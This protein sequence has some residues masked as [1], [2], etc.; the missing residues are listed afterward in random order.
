MPYDTTTPAFLNEP[1]IDELGAKAAANNIPP[2]QAGEFSRIANKFNVPITQVGNDAT[3]YQELDKNFKST[4]DYGDFVA[5]APHAADWMRSN[6]AHIAASANGN[7]MTFLKQ[8]ND[9]RQFT[10]A[11]ERTPW[12]D[13]VGHAFARGGLQALNVVPGALAGIKYA[14]KSAAKNP[15]A[16]G[17]AEETDG[18]TNF[19]ISVEQ[20]R[21]N[22]AD[23]ER[24]Q[25]QSI[26]Q[27]AA[28]TAIE[29]GLDIVTTGGPMAGARIGAVKA[30]SGIAAR[31]ATVAGAKALSAE[32]IILAEKG[33]KAGS[34]AVV[35]EQA[36]AAFKASTIKAAA[37]K[38][39]TILAAETS[40]IQSF[41]ENLSSQQ[42]QG[43][44]TH[45]SASM[46]SQ[47]VVDG[48]ITGVFTK[49]GGLTAE[50]SL[51]H[52]A[53]RVRNLSEWGYEWAKDS[54]SEFG[55]EFSQQMNQNIH[56]G[57][58]VLEGAG[59]A[60]LLGALAAG[61]MNIPGV[62]TAFR[63][64]V[65][66]EVNKTIDAHNAVGSFEVLNKVIANVKTDPTYS[67]LEGSP[68][69]QISQLNIALAQSEISHLSF[70]RE[71]I[72]AYFAK[73]GLD[74]VTVFANMK[75]TESFNDMS[76]PDVRVE[77][78][79]LLQQLM[80]S[81][82]SPHLLP[83]IEMAKSDKA[84]MSFKSAVK[85]FSTLTDFE[86]RS[87]KMLDEL[88]KTPMLPSGVVDDSQD[89]VDAILPEWK[90]AEKGVGVAP[91]ER[92][93]ANAVI[94]A[95]FYRQ[96][97]ETV[98][99]SGTVT[100]LVTPKQL[101]DQAPL[102]AKRVAEATTVEEGLAK[103]GIEA[104][105]LKEG[106]VAKAPTKAR[107]FNLGKLLATLKNANATTLAHES[108]HSFLNTWF[109]LSAS[110]N[111]TA[112]SRADLESLKLWWMGT[113]STIGTTQ[114]AEISSAA[115]AAG[116]T[117]EAFY[118]QEIEKLGTAEQ[119]HPA[120]Y[121][122]A[123]EIF[124][125]GWE[126]YLA[127][128]NAPT[129]SL[130]KIFNNFGKWIGSLV[131]N[132]F[133]SGA[134]I[135]K[136][137]RDVFGRMLI[138]EADIQ[139]DRQAVERAPKPIFYGT[140][141]PEGVS[142]ESWNVYLKVT[143]KERQAEYERVLE[144]YR[145]LIS[146]EHAKDEK[147]AL[148][149]AES[150]ARLEVAQRPEY[151]AIA[152]LRR[153]TDEMNKNLDPR[154]GVRDMLPIDLSKLPSETPEDIAIQVKLQSMG[155][156]AKPESGH[157]SDNNVET[158]TTLG[159]ASVSDMVD[160]LLV[161]DPYE[162][163]VARATEEKYVAD[164][165]DLNNPDVM[166]SFVQSMFSSEFAAAELGVIYSKMRGLTT[167]EQA[168]VSKREAVSE[169]KEK[170]ADREQALKDKIQEAKNKMSS[171]REMDKSEANAL[172]ASLEG[173]L[174][175]SKA[176][177]QSDKIDTTEYEG[178][179][180]AAEKDVARLNALMGVAQPVTYEDSVA[181]EVALMKVHA[182]NRVER[183]L[184][185]DVTQ[186]AINSHRRLSER[187]AEHAN[188]LMLKEG[189]DLEQA[190]SE[191]RQQI[192]NS[193][194]A[195]KM[196]EVLNRN[197]HAIQVISRMSSNESLNNLAKGGDW[198]VVRA[199]GTVSSYRGENGE[200]KAKAE[201]KTL[202]GDKAGNVLRRSD[203][204][205]LAA[206]KI[207]SEYSIIKERSAVTEA[208]SSLAP[209]EIGP[210]P[211]TKKH[212]NEISNLEFNHIAGALE[213]LEAMA[214]D[215]D[216]V[217]LAGRVQDL[218]TIEAD[219]VKQLSTLAVSK[220]DPEGGFKERR[221]ADLDNILNAVSKFSTLL[222]KA[223]GG[224]ADGFFFRNLYKSWVKSNEK[225]AEL[226]NSVL[227]KWS[228]ARKLV[229]HLNAK[230]VIATLGGVGIQRNQLHMVAMHWG[231]IEGQERLSS[232][233][234]RQN[235][236]TALEALSSDEIKYVNALHEVF[237]NSV[238]PEIAAMWSRVGTKNIIFKEAVPTELGNGILTGG[239]SHL[240][241]KEGVSEQVGIDKEYVGGVVGP[242]VSHLKVVAGS[243][244]NSETASGFELS[245]DESQQL[246]QLEKSIRD[247]AFREY[248]IEAGKVMRSKAIRTAMN[249]KLGQKFHNH[250]S[251]ELNHVIRGNP[252]PNG[253]VA[254]FMTR[255]RVAKSAWVMAGS[256]WVAL[257]QS[258]GLS[259][260]LG[261]K[262]L[263]RN[264]AERWKRVVASAFKNMFTLLD[265]RKLIDEQ[266]SSMK[267]RGLNNFDYDM[268]EASAE[269]TKRG[270]VLSKANKFLNAPIRFMQGIVD[271][272][273]YSAFYDKFI[274]LGHSPEDA[275]ILAF[276]GVSDT[277]GGAETIDIPDKMSN[278]IIRTLN[279]FGS[280]KLTQL[281]QMIQAGAEVKSIKDVEGLANLAH[282]V[283]VV[284]IVPAIAS[285]GLAH[286]VK[287]ADFGPG[288]DDNNENPWISWGVQHMLME[289]GSLVPIAGS[290]LSQ[291]VEGRQPSSFAFLTP[292]ISFVRGAYSVVEVGLG[293]R[294]KDGTPVEF[295]I[296][297]LY[298]A[299]P[300]TTLALPG[301]AAFGRALEWSNLWYQ[302]KVDPAAG[303]VG[304]I[305]GGQKPK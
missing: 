155:V 19:V 109:D 60:G 108:A 120:V 255:M 300:L 249:A 226:V 158:A 164:E 170:S 51:A 27:K 256:M 258:T 178:V 232:Q 283:A 91:A 168:Q 287:G 21:R 298:D 81:K 166:T 107:G 247:I 288:D 295:D 198:E 68:E 205:R 5:N 150:E 23:S 261:S 246:F 251:E 257:Q 65:E 248:S 136:E 38:S 161:A 103:L 29:S 128:G 214:K 193:L 301:G 156:G 50:L 148:A 18:L 96:M 274:E 131:R 231:N 250:L 224:K 291:A 99:R 174:A 113:Y 186:A 79:V 7:S 143:T 86:E 9:I 179:L 142:Q 219:A 267:K 28:S 145:K 94:T 147:E 199:D 100:K 220:H 55:E 153:V 40:A 141:K 112:E 190:A 304:A 204:Y 74:P 124:A 176:Q 20:M 3:Y 239:Y 34:A 173:K 165:L 133:S 245:L 272:I 75:A 160:T 8:L 102:T 162:D 52:K 72:S 265:S 4:E 269:L 151:I 117:P 209:G 284:M 242:S 286:L 206:E 289:M 240:A 234:G 54:A 90:A 115:S 279:Q 70:N 195:N 211:R 149:K 46:I 84:G 87:Q 126:S 303:F 230:E 127:E 197:R 129:S 30:I 114:G 225:H 121:T 175:E 278:Q 43:L 93:K 223:D 1:I 125:E 144:K 277:Q 207:L 13:T 182:D 192:W 233:Y 212:V 299:V 227:S 172:V 270:R 259:N 228:V 237:E 292:G 67:N 17:T 171:L 25:S 201:H 130:K 290:S 105:P 264:P 154:V 80:T 253:G 36:I 119:A 132:A 280:Y 63:K 185:V 302:G 260:T 83:V 97:A 294:N 110:N 216:K 163:A 45:I 58:P 305:F 78:A 241:Y 196:Q 263:G 140:E 104:K 73:Q 41:R 85:H 11:R 271:T 139:K 252:P 244:E 297:G 32:A 66:P 180:K 235:V 188:R 24:N 69:S 187:A 296:K 64:K 123:H 82:E 61:P 106:E 71:E 146:A 2:Q 101:F 181:N 268:H 215:Q 218:K 57:K 213:G 221:L 229:E 189:E 6:A 273:S 14:I 15:E 76:S 152:S 44:G 266:D 53:T 281:N 35:T 254:S 88:K 275:R 37:L 159:F 203:M 243:L 22:I 262:D 183:M 184:T 77:S 238:R 56:E 95:R 49:L 236:M 208:I 42:E 135:S 177:R 210:S 111:I 59:Y 200:R 293:A 122:A 47:S 276:R 138:I 12:S 48:V 157:V 92:A 137:I 10:E 191:K 134:P 116:M 285:M 31:E 222:R 217:T 62:I 118:E 169:V 202:G 98:N 33:A 282:A 89:I 194:V 39:S 26:W 167:K 16:F